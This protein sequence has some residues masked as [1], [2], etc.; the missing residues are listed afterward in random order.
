[1]KAGTQQVDELEGLITDVI[2]RH[3]V[4]AE[5]NNR[6]KSR[7]ESLEE[8]QSRFRKKLALIIEKFKMDHA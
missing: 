7:L 5:E 8:H 1:M 6:L 4:L 3:E 2:T